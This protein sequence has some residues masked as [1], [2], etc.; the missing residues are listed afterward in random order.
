MKKIV[1]I[2]LM[3]QALLA[4]AATAGFDAKLAAEP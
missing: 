2:I 1:L 3:P 4:K